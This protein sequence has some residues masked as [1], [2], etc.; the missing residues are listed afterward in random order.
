MTLTLDLWLWPWP[1][2]FDLWTWPSFNVKR[3][4]LTYF[5]VTSFLCSLEF[6][7]FHLIGHTKRCLQKNIENFLW[8]SF[9][10]IYCTLQKPMYRPCDLD[11]WPMKVNYF[12]WIDY[13]PISVLYKFDIDTSTNS[14]EIKYLNIEMMGMGLLHVKRN[15]GQIWR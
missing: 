3:Q 2:T 14:R 15:T 5:F 13:Q 4:I 9:C 8:L 7:L 11:L 12:L 6:L 1:L 10:D